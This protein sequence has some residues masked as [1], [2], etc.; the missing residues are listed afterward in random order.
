[1]DTSKKTADLQF[2]VDSFFG[3]VEIV[4]FQYVSFRKSS[5]VHKNC[6]H[7]NIPFLYE[8]HH[9]QNAN[10]KQRIEN[11]IKENQGLNACKQA[12]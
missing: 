1:M 8:V 2:T 11:R 12:L 9:S 5:F 4:N 6:K 3:E 7:W 10:T